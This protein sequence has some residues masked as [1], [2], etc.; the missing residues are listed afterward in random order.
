MVKLAYQDNET[1]RRAIQENEIFIL[2]RLAVVP[3]VVRTDTV[4]SELI[5]HILL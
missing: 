2:R 3:R 1:M 5:F 4:K